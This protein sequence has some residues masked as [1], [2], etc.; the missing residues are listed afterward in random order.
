MCAYGNEAKYRIK[1]VVIKRN[2]ITQPK[3]EQLEWATDVP[4]VMCESFFDYFGEN[5]PTNELHKPLNIQVGLAQIINNFDGDE[6]L[7]VLDCDMFHLTP[8]YE[9]HVEDD[10]LIVSD[11]YEE[12]HLKRLSTNRS[13]IEIYIENGGRFYNGGFVPIIGKV[14]TLKKILPEWIA[15]HRHILS[16]RHPESIHWWAGMYALQAACEKNKI[17]MT[18]EDCCYVPGINELADSHYI[19]HYACDDKF[20]KRKYPDI[21]LSTFKDNAFYKRILNWP[22]L[23][24]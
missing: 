11:I 15:V 23:L 20:D 9:T 10:Q 5:T 8:R 3:H 1:A 24:R 13:V 4:H 21:D 18:A 17:R 12:W 16:L 19:C 22:N 14:C 2:D 7:E 6:V